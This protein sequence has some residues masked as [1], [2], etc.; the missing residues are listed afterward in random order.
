VLSLVLPFAVVPLVW[1][2]SRRDIMGEL[3]NSRLIRSLAV[4]VAAMVI[5]MNVLLLG[6]TAFG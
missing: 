4:L 1:L 3:V 2:T 5:G 6:V